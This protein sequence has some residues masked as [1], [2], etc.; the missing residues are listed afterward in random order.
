MRVRN[1]K[2]K[3]E[4]L[5]SSDYV[6]DNPSFYKGKWKSKFNNDNKICVEIGLVNVLLFMKWL[7]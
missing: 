7:D 4:I 1:V 3:E 2:N 6:V 5:K